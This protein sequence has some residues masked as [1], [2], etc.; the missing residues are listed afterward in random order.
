LYYQASRLVAAVFEPRLPLAMLVRQQLAAFEQEIA[1]LDDIGGVAAKDPSNLRSDSIE[2]GAL[3]RL[4]CP[5]CFLRLRF[6][7]IK[8]LRANAASAS[9]SARGLSL[10]PMR[11]GISSGAM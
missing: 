9:L 1:D 4:Y 3:L 6:L 7:H 8:N 10:R 5:L 2:L 11:S